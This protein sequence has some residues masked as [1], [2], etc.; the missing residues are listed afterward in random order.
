MKSVRSASAHQARGKY[1]LSLRVHVFYSK[2][3]FVKLGHTEA[4]RHDIS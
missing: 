3:I 1:D 4:R 2:E